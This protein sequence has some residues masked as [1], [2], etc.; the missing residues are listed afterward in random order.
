MSFCEEF[1]QYVDYA[2][3]GVRLPEII[4][5]DKYYKSLDISSEIS[6]YEFLRQLCLKAVKDKKINKFHNKTLYYERIKEELNILKEL[7]FV[8]YILLNWDVLNHC[9]ENDIPT[10][11]GRGSAAGSLVLYLIGVTQVDPIKYN[12]F[13][14]RFV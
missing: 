5:E 7:G 3:P 10:G 12:L 9:H 8:D 11:P 4:I 14:E 2:P 6:N 1:T 13:F